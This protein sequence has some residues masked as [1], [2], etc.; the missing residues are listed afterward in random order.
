MTKS[1]LYIELTEISISPLSSPHGIKIDLISISNIVFITLI[2][3]KKGM[4]FKLRHHS[5]RVA[6]TLKRKMRK[7]KEE[8]IFFLKPPHR[9][10]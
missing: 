7:N 8:R 2:K 6:F 4:R 1:S 9:R 3:K 10:E 5:Q